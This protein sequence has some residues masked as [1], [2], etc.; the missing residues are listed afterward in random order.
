MSRVPALNANTLDTT[1]A[2]DPVTIENDCNNYCLP[3]PGGWQQQKQRSR[4]LTRHPRNTQ[5]GA[6]H[7]SA[8]LAG[9][10]KTDRGQG[11]VAQIRDPAW[12][13]HRH[14]R[15]RDMGTQLSV[16]LFGPSERPS[17]S[18]NN[19]QKEQRHPFSPAGQAVRSREV[20][21]LTKFRLGSQPISMDSCCNPCFL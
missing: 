3:R 18:L 2:I 6:D 20:G 16:K 7:S 13:D 17:T 14:R 10:E 8:A 11:V 12:G 1:V 5:R 4:G 15:F 21:C 19:P 9:A